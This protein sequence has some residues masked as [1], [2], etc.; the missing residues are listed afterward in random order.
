M[1][2]FALLLVIGFV[3]LRMDRRLRDQAKAIDDLRQTVARLSARA[4]TAPAVEHASDLAPEPAAALPTVSDEITVAPLADEAPAE[5]PPP[6]EPPAP[7]ARPLWRD[8]EE[9]LASRWLIWLGGATMALAAA[10]FIKLSVEHGWL[11]P[12]VRVAL[13]L[14][15]GAGLIVGGEWLR[16]QPTQRAFAALHPDYVPMALTGAGLFAAFASVYG[17]YTLFGLSPSPCWRRCP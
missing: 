2:F 17:G 16:R 15:S 3:V 4:G 11:G 8:L 12:G 5:P 7:P 6:P 10:F 14:L 13:G 1:E 9:S